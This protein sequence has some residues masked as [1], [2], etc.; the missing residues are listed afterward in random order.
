MLR[1][2]ER[3][4]WLKGERKELDEIASKETSL[5]KITVTFRKQFLR[6]DTVLR[7]VRSSY[8]FCLRNVTK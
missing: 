5:E 8:V 2:P 7:F 3:E 4:Q 6:F 1:S